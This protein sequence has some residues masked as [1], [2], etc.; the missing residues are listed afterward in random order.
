MTRKELFYFSNSDLMVCVKIDVE[1]NK[2]EYRTHRVTNSFEQRV[3]EKYISENILNVGEIFKELEVIAIGVDTT[4]M[5]EYKKFAERGIIGGKAKLS[6]AMRAE[7]KLSASM[8]KL[9][10]ALKSKKNEITEAVKDLLTSA[11]DSLWFDRLGDI[12]RDRNEKHPDNR[13]WRLPELQEAVLEY[14]KTVKKDKHIK[15]EDLIKI[16]N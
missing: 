1:E 9:S 11:N 6:E 16:S 7:A 12:L 3:V 13:T 5:I 10:E 2:A 14:N 8:D 4:L 15:L